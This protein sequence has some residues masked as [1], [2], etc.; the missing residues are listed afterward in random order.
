MTDDITFFI[1]ARLSSTRLPG[2]ILLPFYGEKSIFELLIEKLQKI[3][4]RIVVAT[5]IN[6][7]NDKL[8]YVAKEMGVVVFRGSETDVLQRFIDA[9]E[10]N[11]VGSIIRVCSDNPF[12]ELASMQKLVE[13]VSKEGNECDYVSF[14]INGIPSIKTHYGFWTE[15]VTIDA[16]KRV[17]QHTNESL[18]HEHVT[19]FIYS[20][21]ENFMIKWLEGPH[22]LREHPDLRL[23]IDTREDFETAQKIYADL[24]V[25]NPFPSIADVV[26]YL[27]LHPY[28]YQQMRSQI[29]QNSK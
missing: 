19:N 9:A 22:L 27:D 20:H 5:S 7:E 29:L 3:T 11:G 17:C 18:Y 21:P 1:Q 2:K 28:Y 14:D 13:F 12:L 23:T 10:S 15:Y 8:E 16:L 24:C 25:S 26:N 6:Q 4:Y